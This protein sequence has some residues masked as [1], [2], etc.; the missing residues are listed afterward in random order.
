MAKQIKDLAF[1]VSKPSFDTGILSEEGEK[2][3]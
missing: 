3:S 1:F 2:L